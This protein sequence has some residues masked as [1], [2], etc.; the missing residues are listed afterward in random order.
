[1]RAPD[2]C[3]GEG[4]GEV[5]KDSSDKGKRGGGRGEQERVAAKLIREVCNKV[6]ARK[7]MLI[8]E[9]SDSEVIQGLVSDNVVQGE[10]CDRVKVVQGE[11]WDRVKV[12]QGEEC[13][14]V[15]VVQGE[16][17]DKVSAGKTWDA[18]MRDDGREVERDAREMREV[19]R[20]DAREV[21][22]R[23]DRH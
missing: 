20:D 15:K 21:P 12:V 19:M 3:T 9:G 14:R 8:R 10:G 13:D 22:Q 11:E 4:E 23:P 2:T 17:W 18:L 6:R 5:E 7:L 16:E 1:M